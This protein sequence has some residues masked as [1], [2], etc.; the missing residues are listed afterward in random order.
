MRSTAM[1]Q[2]T[3]IAQR[4]DARLMLL[5][6]CGPLLSRIP[7]PLVAAACRWLD[8][9]DL[10]VLFRASSAFVALHHCP[11]R[12][13]SSSSSNWTEWVSSAWRDVRLH[14]GTTQYSRWN[15]RKHFL[16]IPV[17]DRPT[18]LCHL[19]LAATPHLRHL[20][21]HTHS[22]DFGHMAQM[23]DVL[24]LLPV[25]H[26]LVVSAE[27]DDCTDQDKMYIPLPL[28]LARHPRLHALQCTGHVDFSWPD[29]RAIAAHPELSHIHVSGCM[30][31]AKD[32]RDPI[33][34]QQSELEEM[35]LWFDGDWGRGME[36]YANFSREP[37]GGCTSSSVAAR[38]DLLRHVQ[39]EY[40]QCARHCEGDETVDANNDI[41]KL[42]DELEMSEAERDA[43]ADDVRAEQQ[44]SKRR[45][46]EPDDNESTCPIIQQPSANEDGG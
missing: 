13:S 31:Y 17:G 42:I 30:H 38:L 4:Y 18:Q 6:A 2:S 41:R 36:E 34:F 16:D 39:A 22:R 32:V 25:L 44:S 46:A 19:V 20:R 21:I 1:P 23:A 5:S 10:L 7:L 8:C 37:C 24:D 15:P 40:A 3:S 14:I 9:V 28:V 43:T 35:S 12:I 26:T 33:E 11:L 29:L 27:A 45:K